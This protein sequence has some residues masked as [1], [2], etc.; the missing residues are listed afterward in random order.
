LKKGYLWVYNFRVCWYFYHFYGA[1]PRGGIVHSKN[2]KVRCKMRTRIFAF[3]IFFLWVV[4]GFAQYVDTVWVRTYD[5][6]ANS[7]DWANAVAVDGS[8]NICVTGASTSLFS[9]DFATVKYFPNG[10][11]AWVRRYNGPGNGYDESKAIAVDGAGNVYVT[12]TSSGS[13]TS[14]DYA[15]IKYYPNG[16]TAWVRRY[17]GSGDSYDEAC[18]IAVDNSG[19]VSVTGYS[20]GDYATIKYLPDG[21]TAWI[22][23]YN[24]PGNYDDEAH[25]L[26]L[27]GS[28]NVY[29]TGWSWGGSSEDY[30]TI[31]YN[32][33]G[34][35][36][37]VRRYDGPANSS[38]RASVMATDASGNV[39]VTGLSSSSDTT[40]DYATIKYYSNG[41]TAWV[42]RY[43]APSDTGFYPR[44]IIVNG[45]GNV[46]VVGESDDGA[47][48]YDYL[49]INYLPN[50]DT[51]WV[52]RY[53][54]PINSSDI[55]SDMALDNSGNVYVTGSSHGEG[56]N[57]DY[58]TVKYDPTGKQVWVARYNGPEGYSEDIPH[59]IAVDHSNHLFVTGTGEFGEGEGGFNY[60]TIKYFQY[61]SIPFAPAVNYGAGDAPYSVFC[62]DLDG[63]G[64]LDLAVANCMSTIV[65]ILMNNG[66]GTFQSA[67]N[68]GA[69]ANPYS[70]FCADL[71]GDGDLDL[72]VANEGSD[73]VSILKSNGDG[74]FQ[75]KVD[76]GAGVGPV[77]LFCADLDGDGDLDLA[78]A[79]NGSGNVSI[80]KNNGD[81]TFQTKVDYGTGVY[82]YSVFCA[83]LD[84]DSDLDLAVANTGSNNVSILKNNGDGTFQTAVNY[85]TGDYPYSVFCADLDGDGDLDLAVANDGSNNVSI[86]K[87][88]GDGTFQTAVNYGA[89]DYPASVFCADLDGDGDLDLAV[90][91]DGSN[92]VSIL[93]NNGDGTF[94]SAVN[95]GAGAIPSSVFCADLDGDTDLD[96]AVAN[97][98][99]DNVSI[100][101]NLT[102]V[103]ANQTPR[104]F[105]LISPSA[106][107]TLFGSTAFQWQ[108]PYDPNFGD[109]LRYDLHVSTSPGFEPLFTTIYSNLAVS[110]F[111]TAIDTGTYYWKVKATDNWGA[112]RWSTQTWNLVSRYLTDTLIIMAFSPV[113]LIV[114]DPVGDSIGTTFNTIPGAT[115]H[116]TNDSVTIP[117][118]LVGN[119]LIR[120]ISEDTGH[121]D[122]GIRID[123]GDWRYITKQATCPPPGGVDTF[124][125]NVP[126]YMQGDANGDWEMN[127][128]DV[129]YLANSVLKSG[130][131]PDPK[132]SGDV[133]CD[134]KCDLVDV[135]K[136]ARH[137]LFG[138]PFPC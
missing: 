67:V 77:S 105:S 54:G 34:D 23:R 93:K 36:V 5:G 124:T 75:T 27:D 45:S 69:G 19:N 112:E 119:Y 56:L 71:D 53:D 128:A 115:Y 41:D 135:I 73:N 14:D 68:Y 38:D 51:A 13:G 131:P 2:W 92:N 60:A 85:G 126:W 88:N 130:S 58:A 79:N 100:L 97:V 122:L 91:N 81:G 98:G 74:T 65:S 72:A 137:M 90:A 102:Q 29:V 76:Y 99:S 120:V 127:L 118:R 16:D 111:T 110:K 25:A 1:D 6:P 63:D 43:S 84:G 117:N 9:Y 107:D 35:T 101:K 94:Q 15:T 49:T 109:Q 114:T 10:D 39:Y 12:G 8:N 48:D 121:Y 103:P 4:P 116:I 59:A 33:S 21:D 95:Y 44:A 18:A 108:I 11:T 22:R 80:L 24:G 138:E 134:G 129:I 123:G 31:K 32:A 83:D 57:K 40:R 37:W 96:L 17:N 89:G 64:D 133:N 86:L 30:A 50:G 46:F 26:A 20:S 47:T 42:R 82:P 104:P 125:Y 66:D 132:E 62:A 106:G 136:L 52:R 55:V 7:Y 61:D 3:V 28:G 78:V 70:V 87:N 113:D